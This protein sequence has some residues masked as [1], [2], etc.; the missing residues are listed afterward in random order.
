MGRAG[1]AF[2]CNRR[3]LP[4]TRP[5]TT[6][7]IP[8]MMNTRVTGFS[9]PACCSWPSLDLASCCS[10]RHGRFTGKGGTK[11]VRWDGSKQKQTAFGGGILWIQLDGGLQTIQT[12][13]GCFHDRAEPDPTF[14]IFLIGFEQACQQ[15]T[16]HVPG[17]LCGPPRWPAVAWNFPGLG[18]YEF[19]IISHELSLAQPG[20]WGKWNG[21]NFP[22]A[23]NRGLPVFLLSLAACQP[24]PTETP[25]LGTAVPYQ[26]E[27]PTRTPTVI[28]PLTEISLP[29]PTTY[30]Y[31]VLAG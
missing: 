30:T 23:K 5:S 22:H 11:T 3:E 17:R 31:T 7:A 25:D 15:V 27:P 14:D 18:R 24:K 10:Q 12:F 16:G 19:L 8:S 29:T 1:L 13:F 4:N 21:Y 6:T 26:T 28:P 9:Q 20:G 2:F